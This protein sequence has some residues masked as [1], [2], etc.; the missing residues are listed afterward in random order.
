[1]NSHDNI[2]WIKAAIKEIQGM[3][4]NF[5]DLQNKIEK[6]KEDLL[7]AIYD[8]KVYPLISEQTTIVLASIRLKKCIELSTYKTIEEIK[9]ELRDIKM[10]ITQK[11][12]V[13]LKNLDTK[14]EIADTIL[15]VLER[16]K[17][18]L[19][20]LPVLL[21]S[22][23]GNKDIPLEETLGIDYSLKYLSPQSLSLLTSNKLDT[24]RGLIAASNDG[25]LREILVR[26][27]DPRIFDE[28]K[29]LL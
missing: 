4:N 12:K 27:G 7:A 24:F 17:F 29:Y 3:T 13:F 20:D 10:E 6:L 8:D 14:Q 2:P 25:I 26:N 5:Y 16:H 28:L 21:E 18:T 1:M 19:S 22:V 11:V 15:S 9:L 23:V